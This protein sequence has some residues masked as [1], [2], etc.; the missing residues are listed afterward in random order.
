[1]L[2][3]DKRGVVPEYVP[4]VHP[5]G[6]IIRDPLFSDQWYLVS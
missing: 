4:T 2:E 6:Y 3:R 1:V 5:E